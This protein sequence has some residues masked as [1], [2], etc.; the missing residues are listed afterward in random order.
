MSAR[1]KNFDRN[2]PMLLPPSLND[3]IPEDHIVHFIIDAVELIP[4]DEFHINNKGCG[5]EQYHPQLLLALLIYCYATGRFSSREI[6]AATYSDLAVRFIVCD[7]HPDHDTICK[8]RRENGPAF[9]IAFIQILELA[10]ELKVLK[11][12]GGVSVDGTKIKANASKHSAVSYQK[13]EEMIQALTNEVEQLMDKAEQAD[14]KPLEDGLSIPDEI[15]RRKD[16]IDRLQEARKIIKQRHEEDR[17]EKQR[18]YEE[19]LKSREEQS[20]QGKNPRGPKLKKPAAKPEVKAQVNFTDEES[21]IMKTSSSGFQQC[22]NAQAAVDIEGSMLIL[23]AYVTNEANDKE[24]LGDALNSVAPSIRIVSELLGDSGYFSEKAVT[25]IEGDETKNVEIYCAVERLKHGRTV[26]DLEKKENTD[27][28]P[29]LTSL[30]AKEKM[31]QKLQ[32][33]RGQECYKLRKQTVEPVFGIIKEVLGFRQ[34][35]M[36]SL[37]K[38]NLEWDLVSLAYN[39][40]RIFKLTKGGGLPTFNKAFFIGA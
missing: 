12:M 14:S 28:E 25:E 26:E 29:N 2:T 11:K 18:Q 16:R 35:S 20:K 40:K 13:A 9:K 1:F 6:E 7:N 21:R 23:G 10:T 31:R 4:M 37:E 8:F 30:P 27:T 3:W 24:Q 39:V 38:V 17:K 5:S 15:S 19:K 32:T 34:F 36:R 22:Y 33:K